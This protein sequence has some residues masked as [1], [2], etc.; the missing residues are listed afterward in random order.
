MHRPPKGHGRAAVAASLFGRL[1]CL[2]ACRVLTVS[3][4]AL[5][6]PVFGRFKAPI[7]RDVL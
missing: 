5:K 3:Q 4:C 2:T 1:T 6:R 7:R